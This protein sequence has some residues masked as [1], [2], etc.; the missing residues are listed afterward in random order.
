[1]RVVGRFEA[2]THPRI[3]YPA[4]RVSTSRHPQ[5]TMFTAWLATPAAQAVFRR[6]GFLP[7]G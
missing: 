4:A 6:H 7:P 3:A 5:A 2:G 1:M